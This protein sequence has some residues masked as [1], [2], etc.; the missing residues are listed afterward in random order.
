MN[1]YDKIISTKNHSHN[2]TTKAEARPW[3]SVLVRLVAGPYLILSCFSFL[4]FSRPAKY[5]WLQ[6]IC[7]HQVAEGLGAGPLEINPSVD[8]CGLF[9]VV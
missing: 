6:R 7:A 4:D 1:I 2:H 3:K 8:T 9:P 5:D